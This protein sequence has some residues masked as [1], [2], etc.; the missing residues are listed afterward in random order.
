[1]FPSRWYETAGLSVL[2]SLSIGLPCIVSDCCAA[3]DY[4]KDEKDG[5]LFSSLDDL[6]RCLSKYEKG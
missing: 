2:E 6:K 3:R 5:C 1:V 4:I